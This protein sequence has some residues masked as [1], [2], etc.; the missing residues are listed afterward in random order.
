MNV[1]YFLHDN[2][3]LCVILLKKDY[4]RLLKDSQWLGCLEEAGVDNWSGI[5]LA[6][7]INK[8]YKKEED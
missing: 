3:E 1:K 7:E 6:H 5:D 2:G 4:D 8:Q